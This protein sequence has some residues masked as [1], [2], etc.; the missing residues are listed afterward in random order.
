MKYIIKIILLIVLF[1]VLVFGGGFII[2]SKIQKNLKESCNGTVIG[3]E[4]S[5]QTRNIYKCS[6]GSIRIF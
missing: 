4:Q 5:G 6:D 2:F 3:K 1:I